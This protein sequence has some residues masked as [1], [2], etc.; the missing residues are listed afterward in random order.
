MFLECVHFIIMIKL[1]MLQLDDKV[2]TS[3]I[4]ELKHQRKVQNVGVLIVYLAAILMFWWHIRLKCSPR[5][6]LSWISRITKKLRYVHFHITTVRLWT[7]RSIIMY[8]K[9]LLREQVLRTLPLH[10]RIL[11]YAYRDTILMV[12]T[13]SDHISKVRVTGSPRDL[14]AKMTQTLQIFTVS[15]WNKIG[16]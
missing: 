1:M 7:L 13:S 5:P 6:K 16:I 8:R 14:D 12:I 11:R 2:I 10:V 9:G 4:F 3:S 15:R